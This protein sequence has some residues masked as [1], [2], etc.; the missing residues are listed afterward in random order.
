VHPTNRCQT[1]V[2]GQVV[3]LVGRTIKAG[4]HNGAGATTAFSTAQ[5]SAGQAKF[6]AEVDEKSLF[7][8][9]SMVDYLLGNFV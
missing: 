9:G 2:N 5:L 3:Q 4:N 1:S 6:L 7:R 8:V